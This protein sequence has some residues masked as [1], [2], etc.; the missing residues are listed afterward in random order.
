MIR[1]VHTM[2]TDGYQSSGV[3]VNVDLIEFVNIAAHDC[4]SGKSP[5]SLALLGETIFRSLLS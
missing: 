3:V 4:A 2:V 1:A 5:V